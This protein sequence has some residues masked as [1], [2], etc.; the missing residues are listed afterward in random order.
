SFTSLLSSSSPALRDLASFPTRRSSD[1]RPGDVPAVDARPRSARAANW[2]HPP[3]HQR[4]DL[5]DRVR[6]LRVDPRDQRSG[7]LRP[8]RQG[9]SEEHTSELQSPYDLRCRLLLEKKKPA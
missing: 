4:D 6:P 3:V 5:L 2:T 7:L 9:R 8:G 1:L